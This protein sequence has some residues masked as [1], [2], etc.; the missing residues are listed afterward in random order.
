M[1]ETVPR[2]GRPARKNPFIVGGPALLA[3]ILSYVV[4]LLGL[5]VLEAFLP[6]GTPARIAVALVQGLV[7]TAYTVA[8][9]V[10][11]RQL[12]EL[13]QRIQY[14]AIALAFAATGVVLSTYGCLE[15]AG[16]PAV[17]WGLWAYPLMFT[18]WLGAYLLVRRRYK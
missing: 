1:E 18:F 9:F 10:S 2:E 15:H 12:D 4:V 8:L 16:L 11:I 7:M 17:R 14:E 6:R 13:E 5:A 3:I